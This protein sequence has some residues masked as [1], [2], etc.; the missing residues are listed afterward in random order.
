METVN[1]TAFARSLCLGL[2]VF[3]SV[4]DIEELLGLDGNRA[5]R[6]RADL[7]WLV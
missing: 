3:P 4:E 6:S 5:L 7:R 1:G 2:T